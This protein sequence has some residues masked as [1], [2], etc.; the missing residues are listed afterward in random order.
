MGSEVVVE[1]IARGHVGAIV[2]GANDH[3]KTSFTQN[4]IR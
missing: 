2:Q 4:N 1:G 3:Q